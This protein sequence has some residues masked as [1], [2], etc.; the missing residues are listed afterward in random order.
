MMATDRTRPIRLEHDAHDTKPV[1]TPDGSGIVFVSN[2]RDANVR[3]L[4]F[5]PLIDGRPAGEPRL[6][7]GDVAPV[8]TIDAFTE[9]C[10]RSARSCARHST[11]PTS[12]SSAGWSCPSSRIPGSVP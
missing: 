1:F 6:I 5:Q 7:Y 9:N 4:L 2:R 3:D 10:R 11:E 12:A 8:G